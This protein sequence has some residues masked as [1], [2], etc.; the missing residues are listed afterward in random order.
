MSNRPIIKAIFRSLLCWPRH[1]VVREVPWKIKASIFM[2]R[3]LILEFSEPMIL[4]EIR[5][6][7]LRDEEIS[8]FEMTLHDSSNII[9]EFPIEVDNA[10]KYRSFVKRLFRTIQENDDEKAM[11]L[12]FSAQ[13]FVNSIVSILE[14]DLRRRAEHSRAI[15]QG[16]IHFNVGDIVR[17][18][19]FDY[20]GVIVGYDL[21][22]VIDVSQW[23]GVRNSEK[24]VNQPFLH[25]LS[26][27]HDLAGRYGN[28]SS[29]PFRYVAHDNVVK[30]EKEECYVDTG[31]GSA[32]DEMF[33]DYSTEIGRFEST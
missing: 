17:H 27:V 31:H 18:K 24:G 5:S 12:L 14:E 9:D 28:Q 30:V 19:Q 1:A 26:D 29:H 16:R 13:R 2:R 20:R 32:F 3:K 25:I 11:S 22:P 23:D 21:E 4:S 10:E 7:V 6:R 8:P 33:G 15:A